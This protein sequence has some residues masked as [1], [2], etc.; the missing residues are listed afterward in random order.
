[1]EKEGEAKGRGEEEMLE[2]C[3]AVRRGKDWGETGVRHKQI[4]II[5]S[6]AGVMKL[7][8]EISMKKLR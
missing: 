3:Y 6:N 5:F 1:M 4:H 8:P 2:G 7:K